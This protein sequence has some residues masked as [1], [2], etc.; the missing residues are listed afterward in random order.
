[1]DLQNIKSEDVYKLRP[2][3]FTWKGNKQEDF[4]LIAE[5]V[6][7]V[8]PK[9]V[10]YQDDKP[11]S[12]AYDKLSVLLLLEITKLK[13]EIISVLSLWWSLKLQM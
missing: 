7:E 2:V 11:E 12:V 8:I 10:H 3:S 4:G 13:E 1:M 9:L 6:D 5:E